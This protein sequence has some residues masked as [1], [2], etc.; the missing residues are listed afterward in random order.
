MAKSTEDKHINAM[1]ADI[2]LQANLEV[3]MLKQVIYETIT[4]YE[5]K[6]INN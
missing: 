4:L 6:H 3:K 5:S 2:N 1:F